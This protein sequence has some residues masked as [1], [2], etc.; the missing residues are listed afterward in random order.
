RASSVT[1]RARGARPA[2]SIGPPLSRIFATHDARGGGKGHR[3]GSRSSL[4]AHLVKVTS[5]R[6]CTRAREL[7]ARL[8]SAPSRLGRALRT[9]TAPFG[10]T[11]PAARPRERGR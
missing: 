2:R 1:L 6:S 5:P 11:L 3:R 10:W 4:H 7:R 9:A 8:G